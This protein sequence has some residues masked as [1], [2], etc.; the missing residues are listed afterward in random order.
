ML[1]KQEIKKWLLENCVDENGSLD[2]SG[3]DFSDFDG[4]VDISGM[5]VK[6]NLLQNKQQVEGCL[7]QRDQRVRFDLDQSC[8]QVERDL[9]QHG[10]DVGGDLIQ[11]SNDVSGNLYQDD[12][13]VVGSL[14]QN[15]QTVGKGLY[16]CLPEVEVTLGQDSN[17]AFGKCAEGEKDAKADASKPSILKV[18]YRFAHRES[19]TGFTEDYKKYI[20]GGK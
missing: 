3:L 1:S 18:V 4:S 17:C 5:K 19:T 2:L 14:Y 15:C 9:D 16:Q 20:K 12:Q 7:Y 11:N 10:Q 8:Q 13:N 6:K